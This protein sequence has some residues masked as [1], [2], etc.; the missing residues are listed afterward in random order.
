VLAESFG[1]P[2][3][4][5]PPEPFGGI[6]PVDGPGAIQDGRCLRSL[7]VRLEELGRYDPIGQTRADRVRQFDKPP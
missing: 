1:D 6:L 2:A 7:A 4:L 5:E 3:P